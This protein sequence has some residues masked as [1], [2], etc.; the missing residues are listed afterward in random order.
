MIIKIGYGYIRLESFSRESSSVMEPIVI[1]GS[2]SLCINPTCSSSS[3]A[4]TSTESKPIHGIGGVSAYQSWMLES[5]FTACE[6][7]MM[8]IE[9]TRGLLSSSAVQ[10]EAP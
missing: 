2:P 4:T 1:R 3:E 7:D 6:D 5:G 9:K 10:K 8:Q